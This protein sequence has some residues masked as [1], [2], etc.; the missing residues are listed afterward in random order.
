MMLLILAVAMYF[1]GWAHGRFQLTAEM[2][3]Y[4]KESEIRF[5]KM[6]SDVRNRFGNPT[7]T[8]D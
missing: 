6:V 3:E 5:Q 8:V 4:E 2:R 7:S 1:A